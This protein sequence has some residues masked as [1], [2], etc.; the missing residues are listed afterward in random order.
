MKPA[1]VKYLKIGL[2]TLLLFISPWVHRFLFNNFL[3]AVPE[4]PHEMAHFASFV[5]ATLAFGATIFIV[6]ELEGFK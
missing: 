2:P 4:M 3:L 5:G 1:W 6:H